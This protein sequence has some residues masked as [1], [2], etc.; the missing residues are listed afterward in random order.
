MTILATIV[1]HEDEAAWQEARH[2]VAT[3]TQVRDWAKGYPGDRSRII[4]EK[5]TG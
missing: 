4:I 1:P 2:P 5:V 3:A